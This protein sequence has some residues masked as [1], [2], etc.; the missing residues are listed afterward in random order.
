MRLLKFLITLALILP[1]YWGI[2]QEGSFTASVSQKEVGKNETFKITFKLK[3]SGKNF[4]PPDFNFFDVVQRGKYFN[5]VIRNNN[6]SKEEVREYRL[7]PTKKGKFEIGAASVKMNGKTVKTDPIPIK[8]TKKSEKDNRKIVEKIRRKLFLKCEISD[9]NPYKGEQIIV[10]YKL[11]YAING[12]GRPKKAQKP[13]FNDF[14]Q[15]EIDIPKKQRE[16]RVT[17]KGKQFVENKLMKVALF[18]QRS[19]ELTID[20]LA[21]TYDIQYRDSRNRNRGFF[22]QYDVKTVTVDIDSDPQ[23]IDVKPLPRNKPS[24]FSGL[25][26]KFEMNGS[27]N[28]KQTMTDDP[29]SLTINVSGRGNLNLLQPFNLDLPPVFE[30]YSPKVKEN[31]G[32]NNRSV[33]GRK[34]MEYLLIPRSPGKYKIDPVEF[35]Y[36]DPN[37]GK[38]ITHKTPRY[39]VRVNQGAADVDS[40][41]VA[42][43][44]TSDQKD[45]EVIN[46]DIRYIKRDPGSL[47][48]GTSNFVFS[49]PFWG[50]TIAPFLLMGGMIY[51]RQRMTNAP[52]SP[53]DLRAK[54]AQKVARKKLKTA[55]KHLQ[56]D[57]EEG[58]YES[59]SQAMWGYAGDKM[60]IPMAEMMQDHV[61][62]VFEEK[63]VD[64]N[65]IREFLGIIDNCEQAR[66][67]P[68]LGNFDMSSLYQKAEEVILSIERQLQ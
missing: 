59:L 39:N 21:L 42:K 38:Y 6:F 35:T 28:K 19:G 5:R 48:K 37:Q 11:Y 63:G 36:F 68:S 33:R 9:K 10:T 27:L 67:A 8:V 56:N 13:Q 49:G 15:E 20:P 22:N 65:Q 64:E 2:G 25:V 54:R 3:G 7:K 46:E 26:G 51:Y 44:K 55:K 43:R 58:F 62:E 31:I 66:F 53:V 41:A 40:G 16:K 47:Q 23:K 17:V 24:S 14:W 18:A 60:Q 4:Q 32:T 1:S 57:N 52:Y 12:L 29:I 50:L 45:I 30:S 34:T 61:R